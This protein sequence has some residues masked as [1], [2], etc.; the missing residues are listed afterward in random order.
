MVDP[1][2][3]AKCPHCQS[4]AVVERRGL[5]W[6]VQCGFRVYAGP[7]ELVWDCAEENKMRTKGHANFGDALVAWDALAVTNSPQPEQVAA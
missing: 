6:V 2:Q 7:S 5:A 4:D 1:I 3:V